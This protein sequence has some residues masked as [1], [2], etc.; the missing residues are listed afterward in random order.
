MISGQPNNALQERIENFNEKINS[1]N[2]LFALIKYPSALENQIFYLSLKL[3][4]WENFNFSNCQALS[5]DLDRKIINGKGEVP[6]ELY[7]VF[8]KQSDAHYCPRCRGIKADV[9]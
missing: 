4:N 3:K 9:K 8:T 6:I 5:R 1:F 2:K 7:S